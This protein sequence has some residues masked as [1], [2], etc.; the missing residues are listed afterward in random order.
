MTDDSSPIDASGA[1]SADAPST[2]GHDGRFQVDDRIEK[3]LELLETAAIDAELATGRAEET[4]EQAKRHILVRLGIIVAGSLVT[5]V[6]LLLLV[7]PGPGW[8]VIF[9]GLVMLSPEVPFAA[10]MVDQVRR[11]LPQDEDG[12]MPMS[13]IVTM[14]VMAVLAIGASVWWFVLR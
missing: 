2:G 5:F 11:R 6:G 7:L 3:R 4:I 8:V 14:V 13:A 1:R 10:R 9:I 12:K